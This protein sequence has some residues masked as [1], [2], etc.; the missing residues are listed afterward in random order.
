MYAEY[1]KNKTDLKFQK[2]K[3]E[4]RPKNDV[5]FLISNKLITILGLTSTV[6]NTS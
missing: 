4:L 1:M 3:E 5:F 6:Q 2:L